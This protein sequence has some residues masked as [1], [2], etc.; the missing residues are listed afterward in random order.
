MKTLKPSCSNC[1]FA[2]DFRNHVRQGEQ[3]QC[4]KAEELFGGE[5]WVDI[6]K[7]KNGQDL[8]PKCGEHEEFAVEDII[9]VKPRNSAP[10]GNALR[11]CG[12]CNGAGQIRVKVLVGYSM[13][14]CT[15]CN[16]KGRY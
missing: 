15:T 12:A 9:K 5:R 16:G 2:K 6:R 7:G 13:K 11:K 8:K 3:V 14:V 1:K 4:G 10:K